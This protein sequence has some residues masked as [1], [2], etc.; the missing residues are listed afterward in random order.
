MEKANRAHE[1]AHQHVGTDEKATACN[2]VAAKLV[3]T[4]DLI[5]NTHTEQA[6]NDTLTDTG[7][8]GLGVSG[9]TSL[10]PDHQFLELKELGGSLEF[11]KTEGFVVL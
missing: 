11:T 5:E 7:F 3:I 2:V 10:S 4:V 8:T 1:R 6:H 9:D